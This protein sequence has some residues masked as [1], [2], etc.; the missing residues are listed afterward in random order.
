MISGDLPPSSIVACFICE[1]ASA[2]TFLPVGTE[3]VN[4][5]LATHRVAGQCRADIAKALHDV[6]QPVRQPGLGEDFGQRQ[7]GQRRVLGRLEDHRV[8]HGER[9]RGLPAGALDRIVPGAD[10][11]ADAERL[12]ARV[13]EG[14]AEIDEVAVEAGDDAAEEL[15]RVGGGG[16]VGDQRF[17]D[18]LA[19]VERLQPR[20]L[21][22]AL[23]QQVGGA[24]QDAAALDRL[25]PRPGR[26]RRAR[27]LDGEL[28][29]VGRRGVE[30]GDRLAGRGID[31]RERRALLVLD[32]A[33]R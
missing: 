19:G 6:E 3:P 32:I 8:A 23:A 20:Q 21:C 18:R 9:R 22:V 13:G 31:D 1:P 30:L 5:T 11:D 25:Q 29:D 7:R 15:Q 26:L 33:G 2:S 14:S 4:E 16:G 17:L 24:A 10:A 12:A 28:D 27:R